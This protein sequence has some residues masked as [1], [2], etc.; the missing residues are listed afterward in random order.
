MIQDVYH[1][2]KASKYVTKKSEAKLVVLPHDVY[3]VKEADNI[4]TLFDTIIERLQK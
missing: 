3:A 4:F 2:Q 1:S